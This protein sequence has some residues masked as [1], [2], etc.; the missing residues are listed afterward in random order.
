MVVSTA[1][2]QELIQSQ[3]QKILT[4]PLEQESTFMAAGPRIV[5]SAS[6]VRFPKLDADTSTVGYVAEGADIPQ[7]DIGLSE[8]A[9]MPSTMQSFKRI[10]PV[11]HEALRASTIDL[12]SIIQAALVRWMASKVDAAFYGSGGNG[13]TTIMGAFAQPG[14]QTLAVGGALTL[15]SVKAATAK[16]LKAHVNTSALRL[17]CT[18]DD[19]VSLQD[20]E[21]STG[22]GMLV[23][24]ATQGYSFRAAGVPIV[25]TDCLPDTSGG[26]VT[27]RA[28]L[29][30]L[31]KAVVVR[32]I[33]QVVILKEALALKG[34][35]GLSAAA[36]FDLGLLV[37][38]AFVALT[39]ITRP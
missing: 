8:I 33:Q 37:P 32:D 23:P 36:R 25:V 1:N 38:E 5:D 7:D 35:V 26:T 17:F 3:I 20:E 14:I 18:P 24:D 21:D 34:Q 2:T 16:A 6:P 28:L 10:I 22:R 31:S 9:L 39:G 13:S 11:T 19:F 30:D 29:A 12:S 27:G 15:G 4:L